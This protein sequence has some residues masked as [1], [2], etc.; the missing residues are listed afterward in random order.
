MPQRRQKA[1]RADQTS[2]CFSRALA[3]WR[4]S[5][6]MA[7]G[8]RAGVGFGVVLDGFGACAI[9]FAGGHRVV[10]DWSQKKRENQG[11]K[12]MITQTFSRRLERKAIEQR[13]AEAGTRTPTLLPGADF[14]RVY[15]QQLLS[16]K[17]RGFRLSFRSLVRIVVTSFLFAR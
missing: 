15:G 13:D 5:A 16:T 17:R 6:R 8:V 2:A 12:G 9:L 10:R 14:E 3:R 7:S 1:S 4:N 11:R